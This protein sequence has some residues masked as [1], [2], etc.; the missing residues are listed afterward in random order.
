MDYRK[1][2]AID[3][4]TSNVSYDANENLTKL[5]VNGRTQQYVYDAANRLTAVKDGAGAVISSYTYDGDDQRLTK[6][7]N[8]E[9]ISYHYFDGQLMYETSSLYPGK[10][11]ARY[12][13]RTPAGK[14]LSI[15]IYRPAGNYYNYYYYHYN[16]H[17]DVVV[18]TDTL[19]NVY[20]QYSYDPYGNV[21]SVKDGAGNSVNMSTDDFN[22]AY[23]Y[24]GYRFDKE[25][26]LYF[27][28][29]RYYAAGIGR[30]LTKDSVASSKDPQ[31]LNRYTYAKGD[32]VN[33][34]DPGGAFAIFIGALVGATAG[35]IIGAVVSYNTTG[36][37]WGY[38]VAS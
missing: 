21:I 38:V 20:R 30:F 28:N 34:V 26:G 32:P 15:Y 37:V 11:T 8:G 29:A 17:G 3:S 10:F 19:G 18:L 35:A 31:T 9:T 12:N 13:N 4:S 2:S 1:I 6:T 27:L 25:T 33:Y 23:T 5:T 14:L 22:H 7:A 36:S 24:A 16:A